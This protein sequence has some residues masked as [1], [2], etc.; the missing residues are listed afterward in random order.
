MA[1]LAN[2][3]LL[4]LFS[5]VSIAQDSGVTV[6]RYLVP[7]PG[8]KNIAITDWDYSLEFTSTNGAVFST[9]ISQYDIRGREINAADFGPRSGTEVF[10]WNI[11]DNAIN[12]RLRSVVIVS[13]Q[14]LTGALWMWNESFG[15][16]NGMALSSNLHDKLVMPF[17]PE[18]Y[19]EMTAS[20]AVQGFSSLNQGSEVGFFLVDND[21]RARDPLTL[22]SNL[23]SYGYL[24]GTPELTLS[25][26]GLDGE[27]IPSWADIRP[28]SPGYQLSG[29]QTFTRE[30]STKSFL[31]QSAGAVLENSGKAGGHILF[32]PVKG[33]PL[34]H[35]VVFT[36]PDSVPVDVAMEVFFMD[37]EPLLEKNILK[38]ST[39][40]VTL[41]PLERKR[42]I[43]GED[44]FRSTGN[45]DFLRLNYQATKN[46]NEQKLPAEVFGLH[47]QL[48]SNGEMSS[49]EFSNSGNMIRTWLTR[50][51]NLT[52]KIE[53][54]NIGRQ[55]VDFPE[56]EII[57]GEEVGQGDPFLVSEDSLIEVRFRTADGRVHFVPVQTRAGS[58]FT[59]FSLDKVSSFFGEESL[60][61]VQ[62]TFEVASGPSVI[63]KVTRSGGNDFAVINPYTETVIS[64]EQ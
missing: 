47:F 45:V 27:V 35:E 63:A 60:D 4:F 17:I 8:T 36:N 6:Y 22:R 49:S 19:F 33:I 55:R 14:P 54:M 46:V 10:R 31:F 3:T 59:E 29:F 57:D 42:I 62:V 50:D 44:V 51:S 24:I 56:Y 38:S 32:S 5:L 30:D 52:T 39:E 1:K 48:G 37:Y 58:Y 64:A 61:A 11:T 15:Q 9:T 12:G 53:L 34:R 2:L 43:L 26:D 21:E 41:Q 25:L 40:T 20:F 13:D 7:L 23:S 18:S 28:T 16:I